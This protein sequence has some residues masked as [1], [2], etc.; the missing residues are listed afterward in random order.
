MGIRIM[1]SLL[2]IACTAAVLT[3]SSIQAQASIVTNGSFED[4][5]IAYFYQHINNGT[6]AANAYIPGWAVSGPLSTANPPGVD[7]V[8]D[9]YGSVAPAAD[10][11]QFV[12]L[13]GTPGPGGILQVLTTVVGQLYTLTF[14]HASNNVFSTGQ[15]AVYDGAGLAGPAILGLT[16]FN[17]SPTTPLDW[18]YVSTTFE[19]VS[20]QTTIFFKS[21]TPN[22]GNQGAMVDDIAV[23]ATTP[24]PMTLVVWSGL[25]LCGAAIA[26]RSNRQK[27]SL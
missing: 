24:E 25:G 14:A 21:F 11:H 18:Q 8:N 1:K 13:N 16:D 27:T 23:T 26:V 7:L 10:G 3:C 4:A 6:P 19:A 15:Y 20:T 12:D 5:P 22:G 17:D 9:Q 2:A